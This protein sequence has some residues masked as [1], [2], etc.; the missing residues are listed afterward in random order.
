MDERN[1]LEY[2]NLNNKLGSVNNERHLPRKANGKENNLNNYRD[3]KKTNI[4]QKDH[5]RISSR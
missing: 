3:N 5:P 1:F 2:K 4:S